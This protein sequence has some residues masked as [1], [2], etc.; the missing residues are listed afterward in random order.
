VAVTRRRAEEVG[1][2]PGRV[3]DAGSEPW[4]HSHHFLADTSSAERRTRALIAITGAMMVIEIGA[5]TVYGSMAL[6]AD[7]WHMGTHVLAFLITALAYALG[8][9]WARDPSFSFGTGKFAILGGYT[10]AILLGGVAAL[11]AAESVQRFVRPAEIQF[12]QA[13][14]VACAGFAVNLVCALLLRGAHVHGHGREHGHGHAPGDAQHHDPNL[15]SAYLHV[16]ADALTSVTAILA[17]TGGRW[18]GWAWLDPAMGLLGSVIVGWWAVGLVRDTGGA[19]LDR[20]P[21]ATDLPE[22]IRRAVEADGHVLADLHVWP[23]GAGRYAAI[24][25]V[26]GPAPKSPDEYR[27]ALAEH[28]ELVHV[29][30]ELR[31]TAS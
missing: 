21:Q 26:A 5:G 6:L 12:S 19:L 13:L 29:T 8:R 23:I 25:A 30:V 15:R 14:V 28:A 27:A 11:M 20:T 9:R 22:Q 24:V 2:Y 18:L 7:G 1:G 16:L 17:L 10:S 31:V 4:E 3:Q